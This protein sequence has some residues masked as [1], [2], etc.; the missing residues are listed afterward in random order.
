[1]SSEH[2]I[3]SLHSI[4]NQGFASSTESLSPETKHCVKSVQIRSFF[5]SIFS[6]IRTE[7]V[8]L[9]CKSPYSVQIQENADQK[10]SVF[11]LFDVVKL[12]FQNRTF[13]SVK[14]LSCNSKLETKFRIWIVLASWKRTFYP[15][16]EALILQTKIQI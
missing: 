10:N 9:L 4:F 1:M 8:V 5:W 15:K 7:Y 2:L 11:E 16:E 14:N 13:D 6:C 12:R 3:H